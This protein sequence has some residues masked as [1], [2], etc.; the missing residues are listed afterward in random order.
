MSNR[1]YLPYIAGVAV[2]IIFGMS[3]MFT[4]QA[5]DSFGTFHLLAFRFTLAALSLTVL[6]LTGI[7]RLQF[8]NKP[9]KEL[10]LLCFFQPIAYFIFE[11]IG[12]KN[13]SSSQAGMMIALIPVV[14]TLMAIF[15]LGEKPSRAQGAFVVVS[16]IGV[17]FI[18]A[19]S[20]DLSGAGSL[21][22]LAALIGAVIT[23]A[24]YSILSRKLS[25]H[26]SPVEITF[27]MMWAGAITFNVIA[28]ITSASKGTLSTYFA[29]FAS[30][31][32]VS[33]I[34]YLGI[35]SSIFAFFMLNYTLS[36]LTASSSAVFSNLT[37]VVSIVAGV[38]VRHEPFHWYQLIGAAMIIL[39][40]WG[41]NYY[42]IKNMQ[43]KESQIVA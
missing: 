29:G 31:S 37:T 5:L 12:V 41:T 34:L 11:T 13:T 18:I 42:G 39:G 32:A 26:F 40:V 24:T 35:L 43:K 38:F 19:L 7:M 3:F 33:A 25:R 1:K 23:G 9:M 15:F 14:V 8:K 6:A 28:V 22:G 2:S 30:F 17:V 36:K 4:K 16:V 20:G 21:I 27:V 10:I